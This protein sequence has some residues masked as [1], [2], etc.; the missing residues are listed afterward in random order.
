MSKIGLFTYRTYKTYK[1]HFSTVSYDVVQYKFKL[2]KC[3]EEKYEK[4]RNKYSFEKIGTKIDSEEGIINLFIVAFLRDPSIFIT[5]IAQN[6][7]QFII[8]KVKWENDIANFEY[9]FKKEFIYLL[10]NGLKFDDSLGLFLINS[11]NNNKISLETIAVIKNV[12]NISLD[13][14][15]MFD[16]IFPIKYQKYILLTRFDNHKYKNIMK[17]IIMT[18]RD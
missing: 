11:F 16:Y 9:I 5:D 6:L 17:E 1:S 13:K 10:E 18:T 4:D 8:E 7:R 2:M 15:P 3:T 14:V 12:C